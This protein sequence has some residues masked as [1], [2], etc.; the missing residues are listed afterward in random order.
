MLSRSYQTG[1]ESMT[2]YGM[3]Q[4]IAR[5]FKLPMNHISPDPNPSQGTSRPHDAQLSNAKIESLGIG[6]HTPFCEGIESSLSIWVQRYK[7]GEI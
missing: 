1:K 7:T 2:K 3:V 6:K 5:V 4:T